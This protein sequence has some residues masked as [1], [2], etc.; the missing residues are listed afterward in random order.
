MRQ[1]RNFK[2]SSTKKSGA[3]AEGAEAKD[4]FCCVSC[5]FEPAKGTE[6]FFCKTCIFRR[7]W[8]DHNSH[9][10]DEFSLATR[11]RL[12]AFTAANFEDVKTAPPEVTAV[13]MAVK[14]A[15]IQDFVN[16]KDFQEQTC[17]DEKNGRAGAGGAEA[18]AMLYRVFWKQLIHRPSFDSKI[19]FLNQQKRKL[20]SRQA[21]AIL[22]HLNMFRLKGPSPVA[23]FVGLGESAVLAAAVY[24][25]ILDPWNVHQADDW[26]AEFTLQK[27][28][29]R[30]AALKLAKLSTWGMA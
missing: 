17:F 9:P 23:A 26:F 18:K 13:V 24:D 12:R 28:V 8:V 22:D 14:K 1:A 25:Y 10:F 11:I 15:V 5:S 6:L 20:T 4:L 19:D 3:G 21:K 30:L 2:K 7:K 27:S 29:F 16:L